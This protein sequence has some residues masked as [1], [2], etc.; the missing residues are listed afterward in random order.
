MTQLIECIT[1][2]LQLTWERKEMVPPLQTLLLKVITSQDIKLVRFYKVVPDRGYPCFK[3][4]SLTVLRCVN[5]VVL[6]CF[7]EYFFSGPSQRNRVQ[8]F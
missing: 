7:V 5:M 6:V 8:E 1:A 4:A 3:G 2:R